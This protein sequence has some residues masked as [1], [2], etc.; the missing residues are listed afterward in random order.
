[1]E[2][3]ASYLIL[4]S[5]LPCHEKEEVHEFQQKLLHMIH[6][7]PFLNQAYIT[8]VSEAL[9]QAS[10]DALKETWHLVDPDSQVSFHDIFLAKTLLQEPKLFGKCVSQYLRAQITSLRPLVILGAPSVLNGTLDVLGLTRSVSWGRHT[11][12]MF[13]I[14][15]GTYTVKKAL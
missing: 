14:R 9:E 6:L 7:F 10:L 3:E 8:T 12:I 2:Q 13:E 4:L 1:M 11:L 15:G 5:R